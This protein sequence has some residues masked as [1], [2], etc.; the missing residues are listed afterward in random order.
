MLALLRE[1]SARHWARSPFRSLLIVIGIALGV[2]LYVATETATDSLFAAFG[3][4]V[5]R[6]SGRADLTIQ[7]SGVG[8]PNELVAKVTDTP[9]VAHAGSTLEITAQ[10]PE[11]GE[12]LLVLGVDFLGDLHFLPFVVK[13]GDEQVIKDPLAFVNDPTAILVSKR[14][15][16][17]HGLQKDGRLSLLTSDGPKDFHIRGILEDSGPAA[18]FGGQVAVMFIDAVQV[19]FSR[20]TFVDRIDVAAAPGTNVGDL[21]ARL[22]NELGPSFSVD[23]PEQLGVRLRNVAAPLHASLWLSGFFSLIVGAFLVYNAVGIAVAQRT[24]EIGVLR[25]LGVTRRGAILLFALEAAMLAV[26]GAAL[27]LLL[28]RTLSQYTTSESIDAVNRLFASVGDVKPVITAQLATRACIAGI[29]TAALSALWP[30]RRGA[31]PDPAIVLR[32]SSVVERS[33]L[34]LVPLLGAGLFLIALSAMPLPVN[35]KLSG[36]LRVLLSVVGAALATPALIIGLRRVL[37]RP[38]EAALGLPAR[39]GLDY[40]AR[41]LGRSTVNVLALTVAVT[42]S[43]SIGGWLTSFEHS[44]VSW[45]E[46]VAAADLCVTQGSPI[47]DKRHVPISGALAEHM[48]DAAGIRRVQTFRM[49]EQTVSGTGFRLMATD[50]D[51]FISEAAQRGRGW[52]MADGAPVAPGELAQNKL[53]LLSENASRRLGLHVGDRLPLPTPKGKVDFE[54]RGVIVDYTSEIG[55][56]LIDRRHYVEYWGDDSVDGAFVYV[57]EGVNV[58]TVASGIRTALG[59]SSSIFV[60]RMATVQQQLLGSLRKTF[61]FARGIE[62]VILLIAL[63]GVIGTMAA[64]VIDR[65]REIGMLRAIGATR[66]QVATAV[67]VEAG[68]LGLSAAVTGILLGVIECH[69]FLRTLMVAGTGWHVDFIFPW[70]ATTRIASLVIVASAIA[71]WLPALRAARTQVA[72]ALAVE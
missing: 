15:A 20:G 5:G 22:R 51:A 40:V 50:T 48:D 25:A 64:A 2:G 10:A 37:L 27:G 69:L 42:M 62:T 47:L 39:L 12:S 36:S 1:I 53:V 35:N 14:F 71:G 46:Q 67:V 56:A 57:G 26:P 6:V 18:S 70:A 8:V 17:R 58:E 30:A 29:V 11:F 43:V 21:Q 32:A 24:R 33:R 45:T 23:A 63:I 66:R 59:G 16:T 41:T 4:F 49:T 19:S 7:G 9:G 38:V 54:V 52:I 34:P 72:S 44:I 28:G 13:E 61:S 3:E 65:A 55:A 68:F 31:A 60:T